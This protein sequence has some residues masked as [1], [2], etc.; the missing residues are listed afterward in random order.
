MKKFLLKY[1]YKFIFTLI[2]ACVSSAFVVIESFFIKGLID[3]TMSKNF[4][5]LKFSIVI[6]IIYIFIQALLTYLYRKSKANY[7]KDSMIYIKNEILS[8]LIN[9]NISNF[10]TENSAKKISLLTNDIKLLEDD[11]F[12]NIFILVVQLF[13]F[14][15]GLACLF[16]LSP[17]IALSILMVI[18]FVVLIPKFF[19][20][21]LIL[22]RTQYSSLLEKFTLKIKDIFSGIDI[23]KSFKLEDKIKF[24]YENINADVENSKYKF[25]LLNS[26]VQ[27]LSQILLSL[28]FV[29]LFSVGSYLIFIEK[30]TYGTIIACLQLLG[31]I[32]NPIYNSIEY[33]NRIKSLKNIT[34][35]I[36]NL[37]ENNNKNEMSINSIDKQNLRNSIK[38]TNL[39][40][41][42]DNSKLA[43]QNINL[44]FHKNKKYAIV[45]GSGS[46]KTTLLKVLTKDIVN[47]TGEVYFDDVLLRDISYESLYS[48][49]SI[50]HQNVFL[51][52]TNIKENITLY[53]DYTEEEILYSI[54]NSGLVKTLNNFQNGLE[55]LVGE[56]GNNLSGG[57][58]QRISIARS[59]IRNVPIL[60]LDEA[61]SSLDNTTAY[62]IENLIL[63]MENTTAIV[64]THR[65]HENLLKKYDEIFVF[66]DGCL[67]EN[68]S[69][70]NLMENKN[71]FY[72]LY[73]ISK[74]N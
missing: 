39:N 19:S 60:I 9:Q 30:I 64:V 66:K 41:G 21:K 46:G 59:L 74:I 35:K 12:N 61:T 24:D 28:V 65:L 32:A 56:N 14:L 50:I 18:I 71:Y 69:F 17:E 29:V 20:K 58:K 10:K 47:Y 26:K 25:F 11:Y 23:I 44:E 3:S 6:Y 22:L 33:F 7:I 51:F 43:L 15:T 48:I 73:N 45:G 13:S 68:D 4:K 42:Y 36:T 34:S 55:T 31:N 63:S 70:E 53:N 38:I 8:K 57:E 16:L 40:F 52:D 54:T 37:Y 5:L 62:E 67:V 2:L 72:S 27:L 49:I 1:K